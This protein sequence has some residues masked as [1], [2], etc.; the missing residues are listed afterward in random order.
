M[1]YSTKLH[2]TNN[3]RSFLPRQKW[4]KQ[5][6]GDFIFAFIFVIYIYICNA[7]MN[8]EEIISNGL[9]VFPNEYMEKV[10]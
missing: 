2:I 9:L 6:T 5:I 4:T 7:N 1:L 10:D 8:I 3:P